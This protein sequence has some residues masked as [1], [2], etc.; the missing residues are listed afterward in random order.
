M[1]LQ[2]I[3]FPDTTTSI[4]D[5]VPSTLKDD[6]RWT[7]AL[8]VVESHY[9]AKS[10]LLSQFLLFVCERTLTS[11]TDD[12]TEQNIGIVVFRRRSDYRT[13]EDNIVRTYIRQ[14]RQ[15]LDRYFEDHVRDEPLRIVIP[16]GGYCA[17]FEDRQ[18][19]SPDEIAAT[20]LASGNYLSAAMDEHQL[21]PAPTRKT[22]SILQAS[23]PST[24]KRRLHPAIAVALFALFGG[25]AVIFFV[26]RERLTQI[27]AAHSIWTQLFAE[28]SN[29]YIVTADN[30]LGVL[31]D[32]SGKYA[33][34]NHYIDGSYFAQFDKANTLQDLK[35]QRLSHERLTSVADVGTVASILTLPEARQKRIILRN[36]RTLHLDDLKQSNLILLGSTY[37]DPW[38]SL[39]EPKMNFRFDY[40]ETD[41]TYE[42]VIVNKRPLPGEA[43]V[44]RNSS[45]TVPYSTY[46]VV[47]LLPNLSGTG[48]VLMI[49]GLTMAG[50]EAASEFLF[51]G[52][53]GAL[54]KTLPQDNHGLRPFEIVLKTTN[55]DSESSP[56]EVVAK[57][58]Y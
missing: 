11:H 29:T 27:S 40:H 5:D 38:V 18:E 23:E 22:A 39:F 49:E 45:T 12:L 53:I 34:L 8:R 6:A 35:L 7:L 47:A 3:H 9:F 2:S 46:A 58:I 21:T 10:P 37:G 30:G 52:N 16:R 56:A 51:H 42:S 17:V 1:S 26:G 33:T 25:L 43:A 28:M 24:A 55:L 15:R 32:V 41:D 14:L 4:A 57:R 50:T 20:L 31:Q 13:S 48:W 54:L 36:A 44:Y 19:E